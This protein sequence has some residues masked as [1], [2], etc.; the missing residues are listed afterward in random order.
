MIPAALDYMLFICI[1]EP[2]IKQKQKTETES[3][4]RRQKTGKNEDAADCGE[5]R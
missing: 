4:N 2:G 3:G 5:S 1:E